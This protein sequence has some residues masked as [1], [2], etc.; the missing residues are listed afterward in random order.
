MTGNLET[1]D[2][3]KTDANPNLLFG[4]FFILHICFIFIMTSELQ[5]FSSHSTKI[6]SNDWLNIL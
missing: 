1:L 5:F 3:E 6:Y 4:Y 2:E